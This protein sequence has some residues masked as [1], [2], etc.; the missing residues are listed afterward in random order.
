MASL[1]EMEEAIRDAEHTLKLA[2]IVTTRT[3]RLIVRRLRKVNGSVL[4]DLKKELAQ[5][6]A[7]TKEWKN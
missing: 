3:A 2:D 1:Y 4:A 5:F 7:H 6:N